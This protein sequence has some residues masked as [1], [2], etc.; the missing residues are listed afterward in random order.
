MMSDQRRSVL[1]GLPS[2]FA[3]NSCLPPLRLMRLVPVQPAHTGGLMDRVG[4]KPSIVNT[5]HLSAESTASRPLLRRSF[6]TC[7]VSAPRRKRSSDRKVCGTGTT[8][9]RRA[10]GN[11]TCS[12]SVA[13][14]WAA[15]CWPPRKR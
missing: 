1:I 13:A 5:E 11:L 3:Q 12:A 6:S 9:F 8:Y 10:P 14:H 7:R 2:E 4:V 15:P